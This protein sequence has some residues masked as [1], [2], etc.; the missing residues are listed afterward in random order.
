MRTCIRPFFTA[1]H[2]PSP[3]PRT[4][5]SATP[6]HPCLPKT[7]PVE[8][9]TSGD[10]ETRRKPVTHKQDF[11]P[12]SSSKKLTR[13]RC[14]MPWSANAEATGDVFSTQVA[15]EHMSSSSTTT[16]LF[17]LLQLQPL[18]AGTTSFL[19]HRI[20]KNQSLL[21]PGVGV[22]AAR[23]RNGVA[24]KTTWPQRHP[25]NRFSLVK[26]LN[27]TAEGSLQNVLARQPLLQ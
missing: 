13:G 4:N 19:L 3:A 16:H 15:L 2:S 14:R 1:Q 10:M 20:P 6:V 17:I 8:T 27:P 24:D 23:S 21:H 25:H 11:L 18:A 9:K 7:N 12:F 5:P 26:R 22:Y